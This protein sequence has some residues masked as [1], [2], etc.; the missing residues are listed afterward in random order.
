MNKQLFLLIVGLLLATSS[1]IGQE[2]LPSVDV[3]NLDGATLK[4]NE[5]VKG[6]GPV[7]VSFWAM[8]CKP[9][10][11]ELTNISE[12]YEDWQEET[13]VRLVA[14][15]IDAAQRAREV[16]PF[17]EVRDWPFQVLL[18]ENRALMQALNVINVPHTILF[19]ESGKII[20]QHTSYA[21]GDEE[22]L[23]EH[24]LEISN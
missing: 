21:D 7:I 22:E 19:D 18:D 1:V 8:W 3:K 4:A 12:V 9:C 2:G 6:E 10:V 13:G 15:S 23:Y 20:Y 14:V 24:L 17:V 5:A 16:R 11:R